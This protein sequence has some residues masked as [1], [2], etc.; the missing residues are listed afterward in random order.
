MVQIHTIFHIP[1]L[2]QD[3]IRHHGLEGDVVV[4][5]VVELETGRRDVKI[6]RRQRRQG[7]V[8]QTGNG[9]EGNV[10]QF[11]GLGQLLD[12]RRFAGEGD[13]DEQVVFG[14]G[15]DKVAELFPRRHVVK[16]DI[17]VEKK[18]LQLLDDVILDVARRIGKNPI[19][20]MDEGAGVIEVT[21][22]KLIH[23]LFIEAMEFIHDIRIIAGNFRFFPLEEHL[24]FTETVEVQFLGKADDGRRRDM[25]GLGQFMDRAVAD[26]GAV[27]QDVLPDSHIRVVE[28]LA[29]G[30]DEFG[31]LH[32]WFPLHETGPGG[33]IRRGR[34]IVSL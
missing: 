23:G 2:S 15:P 14:H 16:H 21:A 12:S 6:D 33:K 3:E 1:Y 8:V 4:F 19:G 13:D 24:E 29:V 18:T 28:L 32:G 27:L 25:T 11:Q 34:V 9:N 26:G 20:F 17:I 5:L 10:P 22:A 30:V 31:E 7:I